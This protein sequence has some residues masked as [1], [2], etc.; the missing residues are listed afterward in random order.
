MA[1]WGTQ[2]CCRWHRAPPGEEHRQ[3]REDV[4]GDDGP[5]RQ[6][7]RGCQSSTGTTRPWQQ[8]A[9]RHPRRPD[10]SPS[11]RPGAATSSSLS[12]G[13]RA[14]TMY[15]TAPAVPPITPP[16]KA[17]PVT[18]DVSSA[19]TAAGDTNPSPPTMCINRA[20]SPPPII[21]AMNKPGKASASDNTRRAPRCSH[22]K[23]R[24]YAR[25]VHTA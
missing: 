17:R 22:Q 1:G 13:R 9:S 14:H 19:Q 10:A 21:R 25:M 7:H 6:R 12:A 23:P 18:D 8:P 24:L 4:G 2:A 5:A 11:I 20:P 3:I 15:V 16:R